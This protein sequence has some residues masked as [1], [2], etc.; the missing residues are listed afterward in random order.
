MELLPAADPTEPGQIRVAAASERG[1]IATLLEAVI[2]SAA[3]LVAFNTK[4]LREALANLNKPHALLRLRDPITPVLVTPTHATGSDHL[5]LLMPLALVATPCAGG[6]P[7]TLPAPPALH[8]PLTPTEPPNAPAHQVIT[9][10]RNVSPL[11]L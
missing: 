6:G 2:D 7:S 8:T 9:K 11:F 4:F 5:C 10:T 1:S 3:M